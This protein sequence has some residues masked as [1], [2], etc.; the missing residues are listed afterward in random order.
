MD[1][2]PRDDYDSRDEERF[3]PNGQRRGGSDDD[4]DRTTGRQPESPRAGRDDDV[5]ELGRVPGDG[6]RQSNSEAHRRILGR[7][8]VARP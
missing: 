1:C 4:R 2:D 7:G 6:A 5:R 8:A 3:G